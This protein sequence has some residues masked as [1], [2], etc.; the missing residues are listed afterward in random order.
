[1]KI[2]QVNKFHYPR[3]GADKYFLDISAALREQG[4]AVAVFAMNHPKNLPSDWSSYFVS[5]L[6]FNEGGLWQKLIAPGRL[7]YSFEAKR[8]F[9]RLL[10][11]FRPDIIHVHNIYSQI[12]PS[13]LDAAARRGIPVVMHLHDYNVLSP[14]Y[15]LFNKGQIYERCL[16]GHYFR[17][18]V[19]RCH[20]NSYTKS[21]LAA[22]TLFFHNRILNIYRRRVRA[23]IAPSRFMAQKM[24]NNGFATSD[25]R[26]LRNFIDDGLLAEPLVKSKDSILYFGR[27]SEEKGIV[28]FIKA[29][30]L[31]PDQAALIVGDGPQKAE[32]QALA[33]QLGLEDRLR[34]Q[35]PVYGSELTA[36]IKEASVVV[37]PSIWYENMPLALLE[38]MALGK[39]VVATQMGG[40]PEVITDEVTGWLCPA[41]N[42]TALAV[43]LQR[44]VSEPL[45]PERIRASV[46]DY[47]L[48]RHCA[49][50]TDIYAEILS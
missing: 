32:C 36:I 30:S 40:I 27:I 50:L 28:H 10:D 42:P 4:H 44:A 20:K 9:G 41:A 48:S 45:D 38:A 15:A 39:S 29:L 24:K 33:K 1:M 37:L 23:F 19:D 5:R 43:A 47:A 14:N 16:G 46:A 6:S 22:A 2:L 35:S 25:I 21:L 49:A 3:G 26:V 11:D 8:K 34:F 12:S 7:L 18:V 31:L 13:I 17:C